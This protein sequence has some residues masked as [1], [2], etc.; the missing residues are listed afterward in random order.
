MTNDDIINFKLTRLPAS[1]VD[2]ILD[3]YREIK[4]N[5]NGSFPEDVMGMPWRKVCREGS[6]WKYGSFWIC[7]SK[8]VWRNESVG[9][10]RS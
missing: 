5:H 7:P 6:D 10:F 4:C 2:F 8:M 1:M 3:N 9:E